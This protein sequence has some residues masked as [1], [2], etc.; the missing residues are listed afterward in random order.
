MSV[1][2]TLGELLPINYIGFRVLQKW[3][4]NTVNSLQKQ[5]DQKQNI[6]LL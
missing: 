3:N 1:N 5:S 2:G 6:E 4:L